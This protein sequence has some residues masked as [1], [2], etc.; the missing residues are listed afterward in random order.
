MLVEKRRY[1][2]IIER[3]YWASGSSEHSVLVIGGI[4]AALG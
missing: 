1:C 4:W 3:S 2:V